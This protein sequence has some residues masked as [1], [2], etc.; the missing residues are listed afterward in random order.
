[1]ES[2]LASIPTA[3]LFSSNQLT[4]NLRNTTN[5]GV[6]AWW[7]AAACYAQLI[8]YKWYCWTFLHQVLL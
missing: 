7:A 2:F 5:R 6:D 3:S 4:F 8:A 1:C